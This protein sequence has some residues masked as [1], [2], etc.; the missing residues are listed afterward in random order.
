MTIIQMS[1]AA[2]AYTAPPGIRLPR[3]ARVRQRFDTLQAV[4]FRF[5]LAQAHARGA[6]SADG[7]VA[8]RFRERHWS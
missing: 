4:R 6:G 5:E 3:M 8:R 7:N 1:P 2:P